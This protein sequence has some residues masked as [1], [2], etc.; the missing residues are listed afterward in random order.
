MFNCPQLL[1]LQVALV[2]VGSLSAYFPLWKKV[3]KVYFQEMGVGPVG[4]G[5]SWWLVKGSYMES[6]T[7][8][9]QDMWGGKRRAAQCC[10][11]LDTYL[12]RFHSQIY[13]VSRTELKTW[14][15]K[16]G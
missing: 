5:N 10:S 1:R 6:K 14:S 3:S 15:Q 7:L 11:S 4:W 16:R 8:C 12:N 13:D 9:Y 2:Q